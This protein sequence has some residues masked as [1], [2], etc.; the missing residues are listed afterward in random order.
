MAAGC[1]DRSCRRPDQRQAL[2]HRSLGDRLPFSRSPCSTRAVRWIK[3]AVAISFWSIGWEA[4]DSGTMAVS[5]RPTK[6][7]YKG[8]LEPVSENNDIVGHSGHLMLDRLDLC[9]WWQDPE[10]SMIRAP[11]SLA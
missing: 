11:T 10:T 1:S 2:L 5:T 7:V 9:Q 8:P 4:R 3:Q 6:T